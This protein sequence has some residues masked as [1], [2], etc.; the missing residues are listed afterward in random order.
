MDSYDLSMMFLLVPVLA[1]IFFPASAGY[2]LA[3][4]L[5]VYFISL[6]FRPVGGLLFGRVGDLIGRK[7]AMVMTLIGLGLAIFLTGLLPTYA[8]AGSF[9]IV[10]LLL[11]RI[12]TGVF[13]GGEYGNSASIVMESADGRERG[14]WS[15]RIQ[16]GYPVGYTLA[17]LT[18]LG[19]HYWFPA[20]QA[21]NTQG[22][23][24]MFYT[25]IVPAIVG[26]VIRLRMP[27]SALWSSLH[28]ENR[29]SKEPIRALFT[30]RST[31]LPFVSGVLA[32][33]GIAWVYSLTLGFYP[34]I[35]SVNGF[36]S[37]PTYIYVVIIAILTSLAGYLVSGW[38]SD[39]S[40]RRRVMT[41][42][43]ALAIILAIPLG[44]LIMGQSLGYV[45]VGL[46]ASLLAVLTTGIYGVIPAFLSEKFPTE[47]RATG[48]GVSFNA[49]F[50]I[51]SWS[52][53]ILLLTVPLTS[54]V[55]YLGLSVFTIVGELFILASAVVS[56]ETR[57]IDLESVRL[58][59]TGRI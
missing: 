15:G 4:T 19:I 3:G 24:W 51:G 29:L 8:T 49:G 34:T 52:S 54:P 14:K 21:F 2:A 5:S 42:F 22:W 35:L 11:L 39:R 57:G 9:A 26:L 59:D 20:G 23:R 32:M 27:E 43:S 37:Y 56:R 16:S 50:I 33:T 44:Y 12:A 25:G 31:A 41:M 7:N 45:G 18:F 30:S 58:S 55:F 10:G 17:V 6:V 36:M 38:S 28:R 1:D 48:V 46:F 53:V 40:G 13:A 47:I